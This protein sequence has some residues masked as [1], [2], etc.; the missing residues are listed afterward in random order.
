MDDGQCIS[1]PLEPRLS[2]ALADK[3]MQGDVID[4]GLNK[5]PHGDG[6]SKSNCCHNKGR[7][8]VIGGADNMYTQLGNV[9]LWQYR[10]PLNRQFHGIV[11]TRCSEITFSCQLHAVQYVKL[12]VS[13]A[14]IFV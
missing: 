1:S 13:N 4:L 14:V 7:K 6:D 12:F 9:A 10:F 5:K 2:V 11:A 3:Y 8:K